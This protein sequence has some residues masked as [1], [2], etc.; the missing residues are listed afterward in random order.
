MFLYESL[1]GLIGAIVLLWLSSR[2]RPWLRVGDLLSI[3]FIWI[4]TVRFL[5][6]FLRIGNWRIGDIPTAQIFGAAF[7]LLGIGMLIIRHRQDAP[8][9]Q[10]APPRKPGDG[11]GDGDEGGGSA[12]GADD[13]ADDDF[14]DFDEAIKARS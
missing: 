7:V 5:L 6:E 11:D 13:A 3:M 10:P 9:L 12:D 4:G 14:K 2:P 8:S 1:S